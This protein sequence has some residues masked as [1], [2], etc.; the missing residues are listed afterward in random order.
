MSYRVEERRGVGDLLLRGKKELLKTIKQR[1]PPPSS[2]SL[3]SSQQP[4]AACLEV[5]QFGH[6]SEHGGDMELEDAL[7]KKHRRPIEY[8]LTRNGET[9]AA[10][11]SA[12]VMAADGRGGAR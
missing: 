9:S 12:A 2:P 8:L 7:S 3:S 6:D 1:W 5:G 11:E 10:D 4:L